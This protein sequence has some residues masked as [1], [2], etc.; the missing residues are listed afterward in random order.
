MVI[1][2]TL[3]PHWSTLRN[4][5]VNNNVVF[6]LSNVFNTN[7]PA[8]RGLEDLRHLTFQ[9]GIQ[10]YQYGKRHD[11][12]VT[13]FYFKCKIY[14]NTYQHSAKRFTLYTVNYANK[15]T[16]SGKDKSQVKGTWRSKIS[17]KLKLNQS[18]ITGLNLPCLL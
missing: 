3:F 7:G 5:Y 12:I 9:V 2:I 11:L 17:F 13:L 8:T 1:F 10:L 6:T 14:C 15:Q 18:Q 16:T 4:F